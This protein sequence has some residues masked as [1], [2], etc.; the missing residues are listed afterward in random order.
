M[1][2]DGSFDDRV[3]AWLSEEAPTQ[4]PDRVVVATLERARHTRQ[5]LRLRGWRHGI[6]NL[7]MVGIGAAAAVAIAV[8]LLGQELLRPPIGPG[9]SA[10]S[11]TPIAT[12]PTATT[13]PTAAVTP[14]PLPAVSGL[15][16]RIA[17]AQPNGPFPTV[18][19]PSDI[20]VMRPDRSGLQQLTSDSGSNRQPV[21]S[22]DGTRIAFTSDRE[23]R[24]AIWVMNAD[25]SNQVRVSPAG[26]NMASEPSWSPDGST[27]A[28]Y[29][30][31]PAPGGEAEGVYLIDVDGSNLRPLLLVGEH[32]MAW[33]AA[34]LWS[35]DGS[36]M[37]IRG[38]ADLFL[39]DLDGTSFRNLTNTLPE[40]ASGSWSAV[41]DWI[42]FQSDQDGGCLFKVRPDGSDVQ[43]LTSGCDQGVSMSWSPDGMHLA[44]A[45]GDHGVEDIFVVDA[46]GTS[47]RQLTDTHDISD[48]SWG[49]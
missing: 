26:A 34:P 38:E 12:T 23:D 21:W 32:D 30:G 4:V 39:I 3:A 24:R 49:P 6:M 27:I 45:G 36:T 43:R 46:E 41:T 9:A 13:L 31:H 10:P 1:N 20:W 16:G 37:L 8:V 40:D 17:F 29:S 22:P 18:N 11:T 42:A 7:R 48:I 28:F 33:A 2:R 47:T 5:A 15:P 44:W 19:G 35:P 14:S 25:G